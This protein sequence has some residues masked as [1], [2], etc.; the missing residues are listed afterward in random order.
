MNYFRTLIR[1]FANHAVFLLGL[2]ALLVTFPLSVLAHGGEDHSHAEEPKPRASASVNGEDRWE[3]RSPTVELLGIVKDGKL[4]LYA[5]RFATNEPIVD[6]QIELE[7]NGRVLP[8]NADADGRYSA[9]ADWLKQPGKHDIVAR[10][11]T[12]DLQNLIV[13]SIEISAPKADTHPSTLQRYL[14]W[15]GG[16]I[17]AV[18]VLLLLAQILRRR[19]HSARIV[20]ALLS[21]LLLGGQSEPSYAHGDEDHSAP[22]PA[23][24]ASSK[25][26]AAATPSTVPTDASQRQPDGS[27]FVPKPVQRLL[28]LRTVVGAT[29]ALAKTQELDGR[30][31]ADPNFSG[32]VQATQAGRLAA[33]SGG[34]PSLGMRVSKGQVLASITPS[35]SN[36]DKGN[37]QALLAELS[38]NLTL[39][40]NRAR[41]LAQLVGSL[42]QKEIDAA[43]AEATSLKAR[44]AAVAASLYQRENLLVPVSG[45]ISQA[46]GVA[47]Q[48]VEA[49]D[50]LFEVVDPTRLRIEALAY[51][52]SLTGQVAGATGVTADQQSLK[53]NFIGQSHQLREQTLSLQFE[54]KTA[55]PS[56]NIGQL[57][58]V[59]VETK[60]TLKG[61]PVPRNSVLKDSRGESIVWV[62]TEA[63]HF[64]AQRVKVQ[65]LDANTVAVLEGLSD[66]ARVVIQGAAALAQIR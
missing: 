19:K 43:L 5:D 45:V 31:I 6:A 56:L 20:L 36:I 32:R 44:K 46:N 42:P 51:D 15:I 61:I 58:K 47:G 57:V 49:R 4:T 11:V 59:L 41:R 7:S 30:I 38:S 28:G 35:A 27:L 12:P 17:C 64:V 25:P 23:P 39:A 9:M 18:L 29:R 22:A 14:K 2:I 37:Q 21:G 48:I 52:T 53:L 62:H 66:G 34:F 60:Q 13:G 40:E 50:I 33:P 55:T 10:V 8:V 65:A 1:R 54:I 63:E 3:V 26:A 24:A 16:S